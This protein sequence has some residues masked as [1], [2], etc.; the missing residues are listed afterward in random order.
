[1]PKGVPFQNHW[2]TLPPG[3][4]QAQPAFK[5]KKE[6]YE[7]G[8]HSKKFAVHCRSGVKQAKVVF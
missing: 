4:E 6:I 5:A 7:L 3:V 8:L 1:M 2:C